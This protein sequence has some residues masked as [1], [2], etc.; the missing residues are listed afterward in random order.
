MGAVSATFT[1]VYDPGVMTITGITFG[2]VG[3]SNGGGRTLSFNSPVAGT[4]NIMITGVNE[5]VGSGALVNLNFNVV[6]FP[7]AS[8][9]VYF[10]TFQYNAGPPCGTADDGS[11]T[12]V[13]G[14]VTGT[15]TY[16]NPQAPP[17]PRH[18][19]NVLINGAGS[20]PVS[21]VTSGTGPY[22]LSGFGAGSYTI[23]PSKTG[24]VNGAISGFDAAKV[25][26]YVVNQ[27]PFTANQLIVAD[28]SG[29]GGVSSFDATMI[30]RWIVAL[31][32]PVGSTG[33]WLFDP[34]SNFHPTIY[35]NIANANYA[36]LLMGDV[37][38]NWNHPT[39]LP[40]GRPALG[41]PER[42]TAITAPR[43]VTPADNDVLI[44]VAIQGAANKG[45]ISYEF[46]LR[47]DPSVIQPQANAIGVT[48]TISSGFSAVANAE[49]PGILR[50]AVFG[51]MPLDGSGVLVNLRFT[52]V[53]Q[54]GAVSPLMWERIMLNEGEPRAIAT[55][56]HVELS[57]APDQA[58]I[59]G[60]LL[61]AFGAGVPNARVTL[62]DSTG[63][64]RSM[65]SNGFGVFR[66]GGLQVGQTYTITVASRRFVFT[67]LT[68]SVVD[69]LANIDMIAEE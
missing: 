27:V 34:A 15:V 53:G 29:T 20:P 18:V 16:G 35:N 22:S 43:L 38:G 14:T 54:P 39:S 2:S 3:T 47:Y 5:F 56:G 23:T 37:S 49:S 1:I 65:I 17:A 52:A 36:A 24:G 30:A 11:V 59:S 19:P 60:R 25:A 8:T 32:P 28:V 51:T 41:G 13:A 46:D 9:P 48:G 26:Q 62:T 7:G 10:Q 12:V 44:P 50:V 63:Q 55:D 67:P 64:S 42:S 31:G 40:G 45:I 68:V 69:Q 4:L 21:T 61:S 66:F 6:A 57:A 58:E 33:N